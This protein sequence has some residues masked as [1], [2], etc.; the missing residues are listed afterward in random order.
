[1]PPSL[2]ILRIMAR[3]IRRAYTSNSLRF[4]L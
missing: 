3:K 4:R 2:S 1:M